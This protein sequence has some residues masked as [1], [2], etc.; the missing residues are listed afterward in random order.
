MGPWPARLQGW[1]SSWRRNSL[2]HPDLVCFHPLCPKHSTV[3]VLVVK[4]LPRSRKDKCLLFAS[5]Q[6]DSAVASK[7]A[8]GLNQEVEKE[9]R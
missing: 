8:A 1:I 2:N 4:Y 7:P 5:A 6:R 9:E 3:T